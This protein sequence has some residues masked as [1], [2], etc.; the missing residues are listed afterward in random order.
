MSGYILFFAWTGPYLCFIIGYFVWWLFFAKENHRISESTLNLW[1][2][3]LL[4]WP[5]SVVVLFV[6]GL[7]FVSHVACEKFRDSRFGK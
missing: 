2:A 5:L 1:S 6:L 3:G 7:L 4:A